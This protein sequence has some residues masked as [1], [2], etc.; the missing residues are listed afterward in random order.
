[1]LDEHLF[2]CYFC[3]SFINVTHSQY[4][5]SHG[6]FYTL[7]LKD[8]TIWLGTGYNVLINFCLTIL[9]WKMGIKKQNRIMQ[10]KC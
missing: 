5:V 2:P 6:P 3:E 4:F 10:S 9:Q 7:P 8:K 1:M